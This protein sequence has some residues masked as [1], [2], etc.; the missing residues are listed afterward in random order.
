MNLVRRYQFNEIITVI[1]SK[2][3][4]YSFSF[5]I[6][7]RTEDQTEMNSPA[8]QI[9]TK[10]WGHTHF[11]PLQ[12]EIIQSVLN[13]NDTLALLPTGGGK[14][15]CFQVPGL[16]MEG[17]CLVVS[18][19]IALMKDQVERLQSKGISALAIVSGMSR[20]EIDFALEN[21][22]NG[23]VK[24]LYVSP[25]RL[26]SEIFRARIV[27]MKIGLLAIDE[28][29]CISQ[30]GY[31]FRP[32]YLKI[33]EI[34]QVVPKVPVLALT[35]TATP[36]VQEDIQ[37]QLKFKERN[38]LRKSFE[39]KNLS[40]VVLREDDKNSRLLKVIKGAGGTGIVYVRSRKKTRE[41]AEFLI[42]NGIDA[43][44]Y[45]AGLASEDR[46]MVQEQWMKG[47]KKVIVSTNAF[48]MGIDKPDVRFVVHMDLPDSPEAYFQEAGR[49]GRDEKKAW[50]VI[51]FN[52]SDRIEMEQRADT[53]F[54]S[55]NEI[56]QVYSALGNYLQMP[57]GSG[58]GASFDFDMVHFS[59]TF[60][61]GISKVHSVI[62]ILELQGL[63]ALS[64]APGF[65]SRL[66]VKVK[67]DNLYEFQVKNPQLDQ[68]IRLLLRIYEG[69]FE[70]YVPV[71]EKEIAARTGLPLQEVIV[72]L[73]KL[74]QLQIIDYIPAS[75]EPQLTFIEERLDGKNLYIDREHLAVR[76][77]RYMARAKAMLGYS[78]NTDHCRS[79][80]LLDYFGETGHARCG[81]C[82][83]CLERN[84][85]NLNDLE[86]SGAEGKILSLLA[87]KPHRIREL[88]PFLQP[89]TEEKSLK[90]IEWMLDNQKIQFKGTDLLEL[91][92]DDSSS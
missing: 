14:S 60:N 88:V 39:R 9:L 86:F 27:R 33:A 31:D 73:K 81:V 50:A 6:F 13:G 45:H 40:Y 37:V 12:E 42:R 84:K 16:L 1:E 3:D 72:R 15:I 29:H 22:V 80:M 66:H 17:L 5:R 38:I 68:F 65:R 28:A 10:Y 51:L 90:V 18:P 57:V 87:G 34:R 49:A 2:S 79:Q 21:C 20:Q 8:R 74:H 78:E 64:D 53:N 35:A 67:P 44:Y 59:E 56:R 54:P 89:L 55:M 4:K 58:K 7:R 48:G 11:R 82:D 47:A 91:K 83:V 77:Q 71:R 61:L 76:K 25:E 70:D 63:L 41:V 19:L 24:F 43:A 92:T 30:W 69:V 75:D 32:S 26:S 36:D 46:S 62:K 52:E 85:V 23:N